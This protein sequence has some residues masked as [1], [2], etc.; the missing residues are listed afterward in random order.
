MHDLERRFQS[1]DRIEAPDLWNEALARAAELELGRGRAKRFEPHRL[2]LASAAVAVVAF[3]GAVALYATNVGAPRPDPLP[4]ADAAPTAIH[5]P[6]AECEF[7]L[8]EGV[9]Y[10]ASGFDLP[11]TMRA[12]SDRWLVGSDQPGLLRL[13]IGTDERRNITILTDPRPTDAL[14]LPT[15]DAVQ[16]ADA[17]AQWLQGRGELVVSAPEEVVIAG[18]TGLVVELRG[19]PEPTTRADGCLHE[20]FCAAVFAYSPAPGEERLYGAS[21]LDALRL[22]LLDADGRLVVIAV[23]ARHQAPADFLDGEAQEILGTLLIGVQ[24]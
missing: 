17:F 2:V 1:L 24:P 13:E 20:G 11:V 15:P 8:L 19:D 14:G 5:C 23:E 16:D 10:M 6:I 21:S 22:Y 18:L 7:V 3:V 12:P 9:E 4:S